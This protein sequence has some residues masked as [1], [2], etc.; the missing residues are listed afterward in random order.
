MLLFISD[1]NILIDFEVCDL[2]APLF[3]LNCQFCIPDV[4][5]VEELEEQ[6]SYPIP[7]PKA[8]TGGGNWK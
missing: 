2:I 5:Y 3:S 1:A 6:H 8:H 4:L 7:I